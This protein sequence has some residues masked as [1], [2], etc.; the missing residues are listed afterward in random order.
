VHA[1]H[2]KPKDWS[3]WS[4][5]AA[6][7]VRCATSRYRRD[8]G[9]G[10]KYADAWHDFNLMWWFGIQTRQPLTS[11]KLQ[12]PASDF[13]CLHVSMGKHPCADFKF[14]LTIQ[15][16]HQFHTASSSSGHLAWGSSWSNWSEVRSNWLKDEIHLDDLNIWV[17]DKIC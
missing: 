13:N 9:F 15:K 12:N 4:K 16:S 6:P 2:R 11:A 7:K 8:I 1:C 10:Y 3:N 17:A 14:C 5:A